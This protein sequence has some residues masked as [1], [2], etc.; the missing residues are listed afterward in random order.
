MDLQQCV[1]LITVLCLSADEVGLTSVGLLIFHK[2]IT[3][4]KLLSSHSNKASVTVRY[5]CVGRHCRQCS[6][7]PV[8]RTAKCNQTATRIR[9]KV[10]VICYSVKVRT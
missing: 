1:W 5:S 8:H 10:L 2:V 3:R 7:R 4:A 9:R 6:D